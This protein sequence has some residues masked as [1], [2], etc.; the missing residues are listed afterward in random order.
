MPEFLELAE[1]PHGHRMPK[2]KISGGGIVAAINTQ[3]FAGFFSLNQAFAQLDS[4]V[5]CN[6]RVTKIS[7]LHQVIH[8]FIDVHLLLLNGFFGV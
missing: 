6:G 3:R 4:H 7:A 5:F 2:M 1:L 8:L